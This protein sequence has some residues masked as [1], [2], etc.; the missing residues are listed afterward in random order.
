MAAVNDLPPS[1]IGALSLELTGALGEVLLTR[2]YLEAVDERP[3]WRRVQLL[4]YACGEDLF[5]RLVRL[6]VETSTGRRVITPRS[7]NDELYLEI[8]AEP[9]ERLV[10]RLERGDVEVA[11]LPSPFPDINVRL[12]VHG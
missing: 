9:R 8:W 10:V 7:G 4:R 11:A 6:V 3:V 5:A 2:G 1:R 12:E